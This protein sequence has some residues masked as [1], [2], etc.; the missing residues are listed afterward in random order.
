MGW[1]T[2]Q[3]HSARITIEEAL[4]LKEAHGG[5]VIIASV[6]PEDVTSTIRTGLAM[7]GDRGV[8]V[9]GITDEELGQ[10]LVR[11]DSRESCGK[12]EPGPGAPRK[13]SN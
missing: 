6:G 13:A 5:E 3:T 8:L 1:N 12:G 7:G 4:K 10:R 9:T 2:S 11:P